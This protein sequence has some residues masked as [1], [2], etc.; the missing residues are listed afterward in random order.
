MNQ[1]TQMFY[2]QGLL[3]TSGNR[4][5]DHLCK[6]CGK[7]KVSL[8]EQTCSVCTE[9]MTH[10]IVL[11][12]IDKDLKRTGKLFFISEKIF[13]VLVGDSPF[14]END[15]KRR[16]SFIPSYMIRSLRIEKKPSKRFFRI[17]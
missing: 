11:I 2:N 8:P 7:F 17:S 12:E 9:Y 15:L 13:G 14:I 1:Q 4:V 16:I 3:T 6:C 10:G 5:V